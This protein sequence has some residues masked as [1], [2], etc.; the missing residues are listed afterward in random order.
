MTTLPRVQDIAASR[1]HFQVSRE[2]LLFALLLGLTFL[3]RFSGTPANTLFYDEAVNATLGNE[4]LAGD[5]TQNATAW[6]F[7]SYLYPVTVAAANRL[8]GET[9]IRALC[10][11]L[12]T[13]TG[14]FIFLTTLRLFNVSAALWALALFALSGASISLGTLAVYD[15]LGVPLMALGLYLV[16]LSAFENGEKQY[17]LL[18]GGGLAAALSVLSK[19]IGVLFLPA[20][21]L[22]AFML[23]LSQ[24]RA[25][26]PLIILV[27]IAALV[28]AA[29]L[30]LNLDALAQLWQNRNTLL[31]VP[32]ERLFIIQTI[33]S[34]VGPIVALAM[35]GMVLLPASNLYIDRTWRASLIFLVLLPCLLLCTL[36]APLYQIVTRNIQSLWKHTVYASVF[37]LPLAGFTLAIVIDSLRS[38]RGTGFAG[39]RLLGAGATALGLIW[40]ANF[41]LDRHWG[42]QHSWPNVSGA[43]NFLRTSPPTL[44]TRMLAEESAVY[45]YYFDLGAGDRD[46]WSNTFYLEYRLHSDLDGMLMAIRDHYF[47]TV[48]LDD[49]YTPEKNQAIEQGLKDAGYSLVYRDPVQTLSTGQ[50]ISIRIY[51][52]S[53]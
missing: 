32:G 40:F 45:E 19:Y 2:V 53:R 12:S 41:G 33:V 3:L 37:L 10:A 11:V 46:V 28:L 16:V 8:A 44:K 5:F 15:S 21:F 35:L 49:Y 23:Y 20:L 14:L 18:A 27:G 31:N 25:L 34:E 22:A 47:D 36:S 29:Y 13:L 9:G 38:H 24:R 7:G 39:M 51:R 43:V 1:S 4:A 48:L 30:A 52:L 26:L 50:R 42:F 6:T 17:A